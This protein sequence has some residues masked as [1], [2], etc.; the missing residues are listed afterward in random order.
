M[1]KLS[2]TP[3]TVAHQVPLFMEFSRQEYC[4]GSPFPSP[5]DLPDS[6]I[7]SRSPSWQADSLSTELPQKPHLSALHTLIHLI[8]FSSVQFSSVQSLSRVRLFV[9]PWIAARQASLS[10]TNSQS[11][12]KF[13]SIESVMPSSH[14]I[15]C[16]PL[17]LLPPIPPS[18]M[19]SKMR[20]IQPYPYS[21]TDRWIVKLWLALSHPPQNRQT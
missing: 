12:L 8:L 15:L 16:R 3:W 1:F 20:Y 13:M 11:S 2:V 19:I 10:I 17:L 18:I 5:G 6:G 14:L 9:T 21:L 4:I 7:E